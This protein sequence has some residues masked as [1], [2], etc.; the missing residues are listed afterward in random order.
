MG[1]KI[2]MIVHGVCGGVL[3]GAITHHLLI[4]VRRQRGKYRLLHLYSRIVGVAY[5]ATALMGAGLYPRF[6]VTVR[7]VFDIEMP[8][9]TA[10]FEV[11]EHAVALGLG[12][13]VWFLV[14]TPRLR[15]ASDAA[16]VL[17]GGYGWVVA[18]VFAMCW[19]GLAVG[20]LLTAIRPV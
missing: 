6:R 17:P 19:Y 8:W 1:W 13:L 16:P 20:L 12:L 4:V 10:I 7:S 15:R 9:A 2:L 18:G 14:A 5:A 3:V 11:K